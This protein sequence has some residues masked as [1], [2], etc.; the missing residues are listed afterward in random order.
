[1]FLLLVLEFLG[2][3]DHVYDSFENRIL[4]KGKKLISK[5]FKKD[6]QIYAN[7]FKIP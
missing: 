7:L 2:L 5:P 3:L 6:E 4:L 1:M